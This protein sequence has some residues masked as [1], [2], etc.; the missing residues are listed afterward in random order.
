[1]SWWQN[2]PIRWQHEVEEMIT[3]FP[4][5]QWGER[6]Q[7]NVSVRYWEVIVE[8]IPIPKELPLIL[9]DLDRDS[10]VD[11]EPGGRIRHHSGCHAEHVLKPELENLNLT[12][13]AFLIELTYREPP[14]QPYA[15]CLIPNW[16]KLTLPEHTH[17]YNNGIGDI[18]CPL[19]PPD[20]DWQWRKN[21]AVDYMIYV[22][23]WL[24]KTT[25][26]MS[27]KDK[28]GR[29]VWIGSWANHSLEAILRVHPEQ[30]CPCGSGRKF[31]QCHMHQYILAY[32]QRRKI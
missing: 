29:G 30:K 11:I 25:I 21:T 24:L 28:F 12:N 31:K 19:F 22:A 26:W 9:A 32:N 13:E 5:S 4:V 1:M 2:N 16:S 7:N 20:D 15:R 3:W 8:P 14:A 23:I 6:I 10:W 17:F 27:V 18:I